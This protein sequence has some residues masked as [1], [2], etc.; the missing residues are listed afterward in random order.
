TRRLLSGPRFVIAVDTNLLIYAHR[1]D[2]PFHKIAFDSL[3]ELCRKGRAW[4]IPWP[5]IH[6]FVAIVTHP[7]IYDPPSTL[8]QAI[9]QV[10]AWLE[11]PN[12]ILINESAGYWETLKQSLRTGKIEGPKVHD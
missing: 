12:L 4:S 1:E 8:E 6:E 3:A 2:S 11:V 10:E 5:C 9:E 7:R